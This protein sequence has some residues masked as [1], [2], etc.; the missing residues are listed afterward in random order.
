VAHYAK[1]PGGGWG[2]SPEEVYTK[3]QAAENDEL[4]KKEEMFRL[5]VLGCQAASVTYTQ[6]AACVALAT[7]K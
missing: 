4:R 2:Y 1:H 7:G 3:V 6:A 5:I